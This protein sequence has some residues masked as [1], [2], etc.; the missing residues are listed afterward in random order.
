MTKPTNSEDL[1]KLASEIKTFEKN[2]VQNAIEI[3]K[4][5]DIASKKCEH[6]EYMKWLKH[7]FGWSHDTSLNYRRAYEFSQ[8][9]KF[10][11][12]EK[13]DISVSAFYLIARIEDG[14]IRSA[15][16]RAAKRGRVSY[17]L[18]REIMKEEH[19]KILERIRAVRSK[20]TA[21]GC[22]EGE[23]KAAQEK[24]REL[25]ATHRISESELGPIHK[26]KAPLPDPPPDHSPSP[27]PDPDP[28]KPSSGPPS[29]LVQALN[30]VLDHPYPEDRGAR[31]GAWLKAI[32]AIGTPRF[33]DIIA[34]LEMVRDD[35]GEK[36]TKSAVKDKA[37]RA[38]DKTSRKMH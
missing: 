36:D 21:N 12:F 28:V 14:T 24:A 19:K 31:S 17:K 13:F 18:A 30:V 37:D 27:P 7:E 9:P 38:E 35:Y 29:K 11:D 6:G 8:S 3:G 16:V 5:L 2:S 23:A 15:I 4:R 33:R 22:T 26:G 20:T 10:S 32:K 34:M 25:M 1:A